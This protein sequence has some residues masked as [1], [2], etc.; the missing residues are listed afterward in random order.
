MGNNGTAIAAAVASLA[1]GCSWILMDHLPTGYNGTTLPDCT[2]GKGAVALDYI[3]GA[4]DAIG[5]AVI[6][7]DKTL[8]DDQKTTPVIGGIAEMLLFDLSAMTGNGWANDCRKAKAEYDQS[9]V[10]DGSGDAAYGIGTE[11]A[12]RKVRQCVRINYRLDCFETMEACQ[13]RR[14]QAIDAAALVQGECTK[15]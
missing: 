3:F 12:K 8:T 10:Q 6:M 5:V 13:T 1:S 2:S 15:M 9:P 14:A 11:P 7:S 4:I